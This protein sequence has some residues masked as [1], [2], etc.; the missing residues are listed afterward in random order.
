MGEGGPISAAYPKSRRLRKRRDFLRVQDKSARVTTRHFTLLLAPSPPQGACRLGIVA[1]KKVGCAVARNRVKRLLRE[2]FRTNPSLFPD[3]VDL[4]IVARPAP[5]LGLSDVIAEL[6]GI[7]S[8]LR[9]RAIEV[10]RK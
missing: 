8:L 7:G 6:A 1:S 2:A 10:L 3:G 4:V 5:D 9:R